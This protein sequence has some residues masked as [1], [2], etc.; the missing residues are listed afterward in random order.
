LLGYLTNTPP[1]TSWHQQLRRI[2]S[3]PGAKLL[4]LTPLSFQ[5]S[6][7]PWA[8]LPRRYF[9]ILSSFII[10]GAIHTVG[11]YNVTRS[12]GIPLSDGGEFAY[13]L[14]QGVAIIVEDFVL[15]LLGIDDQVQQPPSTLRR[16]IGYATTAF[17]YSWSRVA[18]KSLPVTTAH[19]IHDERGQ[20]YVAVRLIEL[21]ALAVPG[22]FVAAAMRNLVA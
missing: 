21:S 1:R 19:G 18:L 11:S 15:W 6:K 12:L 13:Y 20:L 4:S 17:W 5:H 14:A 16:T 2:T 22:N 7:S 10:S 9:L 3:T 8:R